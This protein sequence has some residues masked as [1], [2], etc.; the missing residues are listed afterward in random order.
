[1][2]YLFLLLLPLCTFGQNI[3]F[4]DRLDSSYVP[5][6]S[7][8][9]NYT[10]STYFDSGKGDRTIDIDK[11]DQELLNAAL[12]FAINRARLNRRRLGLAYSHHLEFLAFNCTQVFGKNKFRYAKKGRPRWEKVLYVGTMNKATEW[13]MIST[14]VA[15]V[16]L[17]KVSQRKK[18][19]AVESVKGKKEW[20]QKNRAK[21]W[22]LLEFL[23]Y[24]AFAEKAVALLSKGSNKRFFHSTSFE[25]MACYVQ[26]DENSIRS[27]K[28]PKVK[29]IQIVGGKRLDVEE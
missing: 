24:N 14:N 20:F 11:L 5:G 21:E 9:E 7:L 6:N 13:H 3:R 8:I 19:K 25:I 26:L 17:L 16:S 27:S 23:S 10:D 29:V 22:V 1:M 28:G 4:L 18:M 2:K 15:Y 12:H